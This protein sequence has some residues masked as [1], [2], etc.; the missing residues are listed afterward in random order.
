MYSKLLSVTT[1]YI[2]KGYWL[3]IRLHTI[4][5]LCRLSSEWECEWPSQRTGVVN[6]VQM[7]FTTEDTHQLESLGLGVLITQ[8]LCGSSAD[9]GCG[10]A[11]PSMELMSVNGGME[12][13]SGHTQ[14]ANAMLVLKAL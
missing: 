14:R 4:V 1:Y 12:E 10:G 2:S 7:E 13:W 6:R 8:G 5:L 9:F 3:F 11:A